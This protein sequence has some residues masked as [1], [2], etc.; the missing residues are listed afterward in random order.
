MFFFRCLRNTGAVFKEESSKKQAFEV[1]VK[2]QL[3][4]SPEPARLSCLTTRDLSDFILF[5]W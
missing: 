1:T 2:V 5:D 3:L 4:A